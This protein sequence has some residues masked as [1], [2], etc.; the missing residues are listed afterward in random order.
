MI[1]VALNHKT[2][3]SYDRPIEIGPQIVRLRPAPHS[4][5]PV[6][7]YSLKVNPANHF[8]NWQ[9]DPHS[10]WLARLV[11]PEPAECFEVEVDL[12]AEMTVINPF[13]F[14]LED[15]ALKYPFEYPADL[16]V[17]LAPFLKRSYYGPLFSKLIASVDLTPRKTIDFVVELNQRIT[18]EIKYLIRMEPGVQSPEESLTLKSGSCRDSAWLLVELM[19]HLG[20]ASRFVSG[21]LVQLK[22]DVESLDGPSGTDVDFTDLHAWTEIFLPG[23]GWIGLDPTSG[24]LCGEGHIP[25]ACTPEPTTAAPISG[26]IGDC[27]VEFKHEM[28]VTRIHEDPR[29]TKPYTEEQWSAVDE[30]GHRIDDR[31]VANDVRLTMGGEPT[32]VSIDDMQGDEWNTAAVGPTKRGLAANLSRRLQDRF[33]PGGLIH[34]GQGKWYPGES[35]PRWAFTVLCRHDGQPVWRDPKWLADPDS[36][37]GHTTD[38]ARKFTDEICKRLEID[39]RHVVMAFEDAL[40]Y[41]WKERRLPTNRS[42]SEADVSDAED[43]E[44]IARVFE[45]GLG[46]PVGCLLPIMHQWWNAKPRWVSGAWPVRSDEMFLTPGDSPMGLRLPLDSIPAG[47]DAYSAHPDIPFEPLPPLP[48]HDEIR[49]Q[50]AFRGDMNKPRSSVHDRYEEILKETEEESETHSGKEPKEYKR[51]EKMPVESGAGSEPV[52]RTAICVEPREGTLRVFM[53]P[54]ETTESYLELL[55]VIEATAEDLSLPV[56]IEGY[57]PPPDYRLNQIKVTP[58]PGVIEVNV[59]PAANWGELVEIVSGVYEDARQT[60]LGTE[61]FDLDGAHTGTGGGSHIV[62]G[63][64]MPA[65][66]PFLRRPDLLRSIVNY[67]HNHPS[68]SYLFSSRFIGPTSQAPRVDEGRRDAVYEMEIAFEQIPDNGEFPPWLVDRI[69]RHLLVDL[70]G[71]THRAEI[72]IDKLFAPES[73]TGRLGLIEFRAFE[74]QPHWQMNMVQQLLMRALI[75]HFW[76]KPYRQKLIRWDTSIH[77]RWMMPYFLQLDL[78][79]ILSELQFSGIELDPAWFAPHFEFRFPKIGEVNVDGINLE[80]RTAIE[81][82]YVLGEEPGSGGTARYVDSSVERLQVRVKGVA[83]D[84]HVISCNGRRVPL[85]ATGTQGEFVGGVRYRAWQP[86]SC[87]HPTIPPDSPLVF[88]LL[89][90]WHNRSL[91]GCRYHVDHP[92][93]VNSGSFPVN[94]YEAESRRASR[95]FRFGHT[96]GTVPIPTEEPNPSFPMTLDMRRNRTTR[97]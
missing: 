31:L 63:A 81:P 23:A 58:D 56:V 57:L 39:S 85:H 43:R 61:K 16:K 19:R 12:V 67:W 55:S 3:Y 18:D 48:P 17:D 29:V 73:S 24:L 91:G 74:M 65:D 49:H 88:D 96:G 25:V 79:D 92:G 40:Y 70:T 26:L 30:L 59:Q 22:P 94:A 35:L 90:S 62:M 20:I 21:Y 27:K 8:L 42:V 36:D 95:F 41:T 4:R 87:L 7:S 68:L 44:R 33:A 54:L 82:W 37:L 1:K 97:R 2:L 11:F 53:P 69:F 5:T 66:S 64:A 75:V 46:N 60:R 9:Q 13:E 51:T 86:P 10:N 52:I 93:G 34:C 80:L 71:N 78:N 50:R 38:D 47:G 77:D 6:N 89:D 14:F 83:S 28:T 84:R 72:C 32:F 76:E 45:Q 15:D